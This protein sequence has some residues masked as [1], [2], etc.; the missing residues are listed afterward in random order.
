MD[1]LQQTYFANLNAVCRDGGWFTLSPGQSWEVYEHVNPVNK[2]YFFLK[3]SCSIT[4][5]GKTYRPQPGDWFFIPAGVRHSYTHL[6]GQSF[7]KFWLHFDLY[8]NDSLPKLLQ[9]P[10]RIR[11]GQD[12]T[13]EQLFK[14]LT[15]ANGSDKLT[16]KLRAKAVLMELLALYVELSHADQV[17]AEDEKS[18]RIKK[19]LS[20]IH[21][22]LDKPISN[23]D[24]ADVCH[25]HP[26]HFVRYFSQMTGQTPA[27]YVSWCRMKEAGQL[28]TGTDLPIARIMEQVGLQEPSHFARLFRK[29]YSVTPSRYRKQY[30]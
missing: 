14:K 11:V 7:E 30:K 17:Q 3:G 27:A 21:K 2:F 18:V 23:K 8:P 9:L 19:V 26:T 4:I 24:L 16:Q 12:R 20:Y 1:Y 15:K 22:N 28:L 5:E 10:H 25:M 29:Y 13:A 6:P